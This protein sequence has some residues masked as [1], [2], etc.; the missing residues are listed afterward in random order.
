MRNAVILFM[1]AICV[2]GKI[3]PP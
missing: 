1:E 3:K 2:A